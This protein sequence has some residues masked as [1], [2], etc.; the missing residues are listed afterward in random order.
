MCWYTPGIKVAQ[1]LVLTLQSQVGA[2]QPQ[3]IF[4]HKS[5]YENSVTLVKLEEGLAGCHIMHAAMHLK[6]ADH[7]KDCHFTRLM[8]SADSFKR[9]SLI[10]KNP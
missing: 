3:M 7:D 9:R 2:A 1:P 5:A 10:E 4:L 6:M 8:A